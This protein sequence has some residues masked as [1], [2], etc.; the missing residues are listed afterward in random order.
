[1]TDIS[2]QGLI[3]DSWNRMALKE[4]KRGV[5]KW[6]QLERHKSMDHKA[7]TL[8]KLD[9]LIG[10]LNNAHPGTKASTTIISEDTS[11]A[12]KNTSSE[13][14]GPHVPN[15]Y[16]PFDKCLL[17]GL[18]ALIRKQSHCAIPNIMSAIETETLACIT[19]DINAS[20]SRTYRRHLR[21]PSCLEDEFSYRS[22][23]TFVK[24]LRQSLARVGFAS[25]HIIGAYYRPMRNKV[26]C[27]VY[28]QPISRTKRH[29]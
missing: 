6:V 20:I 26:T 18:R 9:K 22:G 14:F 16:S 3:L 4:H 5:T 15:L 17:Q 28:G 12:A 29:S 11:I 23:L 7:G 25:S 10:K 2:L 13:P 24:V 8:Q 19:T 1:M 21:S 27:N